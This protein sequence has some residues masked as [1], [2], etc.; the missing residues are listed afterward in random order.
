MPFRGDKEKLIEIIDGYPGLANRLRTQPGLIP[1]C[2]S[3]ADLNSGICNPRIPLRPNEPHLCALH[4]SCLVA[5]MLAAGRSCR[6]V[7]MRD[8]PYDDV[9]ALASED[10]TLFTDTTSAAVNPPNRA[11]SVGQEDR[12]RI[13]AAVASMSLEPPKNPYRR[14]SVRRFVFDILSTR[15]ISLADLRAAILA[16]T[17][18][19]RPDWVIAQVTSVAAQSTYGYRI[20]EADGLFRAFRRKNTTTPGTPSGSP[21]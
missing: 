2:F 19:S 13:R 1:P 5:K 18:T 14:R 3:H 7:A 9:V 16:Y 12:Q 11:Q 4:K 17:K 20:V 6:V 10:D 15:W 21:S 8:M